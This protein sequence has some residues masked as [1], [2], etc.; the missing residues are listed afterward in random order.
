[1]HDT[2]TLQLILTAVAAGALLLQVIFMIVLA[3]IASKAVKRVTEE[4][5]EYRSSIIPVIDKIRPIVD[6]TKEMVDKA[7]PKV[8]E[9]TTH[10]T[11]V[12]KSLRE[13]TITIQGATEDIIGRTRNQAGRVDGILTSVFNG[14]EKAG[15]VMSDAVSKPMRQISG[16]L[17]SVKA[18]VESLRESETI[19]A[20]PVQRAVTPRYDN[21]DSF[22]GAR[23]ASPTPTEIRR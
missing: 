10:L 6:K 5:E 21:G 19:N 1:M 8:D 4:M 23:P 17:A 9:I 7:A 22:P 12:S 18:A 11:A 2:Q 16:I 13:Q 15:T 14:L 3:T 20:P